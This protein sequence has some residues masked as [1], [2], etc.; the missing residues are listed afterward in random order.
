MGLTHHSISEEF[1]TIKNGIQDLHKVQRSKRIPYREDKVYSFQKLLSRINKKKKVIITGIPRSGTG[2]I[3]NTLKTYRNSKILGEVFDH[4]VWENYKSTVETSENFSLQ[5]R[6]ELFGLKYLLFQTPTYLEDL[7]RLSKLGWHI[8]GTIRDEPFHQALSFYTATVTKRYHVLKSGNNASK[9]YSSFLVDKN[10]FSDL[11]ELYKKAN[12]QLRIDYKSVTKD[13]NKI[14][15]D[16]IKAED[17][18]CRK[19]EKILTLEVESLKPNEEKTQINY[20]ELVLN[21]SYLEM[22]FQNG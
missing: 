15:F 3:A 1:L 8:I 11:I 16:E 21:Y 14:L 18:C 12:F 13:N 7:E 6:A 4:G 22:E 17:P 20:H 2:F 9:N 10:I 5:Y 19:L